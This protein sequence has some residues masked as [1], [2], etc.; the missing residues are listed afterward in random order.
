MLLAE[1][2]AL[3]ALHPESGRHA[4]GIRTQ[5]NACLAGLL[6]AE[7][8]LDG[9][10]VPYESNGVAVATGQGASA[11]STQST[12]SVLES[13]AEVVAEKGPK[14]KAILSHMDRGLSRRLNAGTW[15]AVLSGLAHDGVVVWREGT[16][17]PRY[18][19]VDAAARDTIVERLASQRRPMTSS[20]HARRWCCR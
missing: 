19:L 3:V 5:L 12:E 1:E 11:K 17:R 14:I 13:T 9:V 8:V 4:V 2:L 18:E 7:L 10:V 20:T 6:V 16:L 15:D